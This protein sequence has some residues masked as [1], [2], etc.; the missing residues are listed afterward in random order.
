MA[1]NKNYLLKVDTALVGQRI[2]LRRFR[3]NDGKAL[4][5][6]VRDNTAFIEDYLPMTLKFNST[7]NEAEWFVRR[8]IADW[9]NAQSYTFGIWHTKTAGLIGMLKIFHIDWRVPKGEVAFFVDH[10]FSGQGLMTEALTLAADFALTELKMERLFLR[11]AADNY[12][13]LRVARKCGF[14][15]EGILR[16]DFKTQAGTLIDS[17]IFGLPKNS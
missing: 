15:R 16:N 7:K 17:V 4:Y 14:L 9:L 8:S 10:E 1:F 12:G 5:E 6:L 2:V 11:T 3:E 13:C